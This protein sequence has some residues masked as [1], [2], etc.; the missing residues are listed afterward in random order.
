VYE[1]YR[2]HLDARDDIPN[3]EWLSNDD[4]AR[5]RAVWIR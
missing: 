5:A 1:R 4:V 3:V 2:H